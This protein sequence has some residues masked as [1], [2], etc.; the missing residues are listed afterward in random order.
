MRFPD[1][2]AMLVSF[3][4]PRVTVH[5][6][7]TVPAQR[8]ASFIRAWRN[9]GSASNRIL[10]NAT[11]TVDAWAES[12][13]EAATLAEDVRGLFHHSYTAMPLVRGVEEISG[14]YSIP[15]PESGS[16]RYRFSVRLR[17]RAAR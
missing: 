13:V 6:H 11:V 3:L 2:D 1:V 16:P 14:P 12:S 17:V 4:T 7:V 15:D 9:G 8:P 5:V 10:D